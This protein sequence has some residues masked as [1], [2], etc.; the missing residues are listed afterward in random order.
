MSYKAYL[1]RMR[2]PEDVEDLEKLLSCKTVPADLE[3]I[4]KPDRKVT[5]YERGIGGWSKQTF[6]P[7]D[8]VAAISVDRGD[9]A[10]TFF[11]EV[12]I[13]FGDRKPFWLR[14]E[15]LNETSNARIEFDEEE[16]GFR[17]S[18]WHIPSLDWSSE[19]WTSKAK[20][21]LTPAPE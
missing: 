8:L 19:K 1:F 14:L 18:G 3:F 2:T 15:Q 5:T 12:G 10:L 11:D 6:E 21:L 16:G 17:V 13:H 4:Y 9:L 20:S 7:T